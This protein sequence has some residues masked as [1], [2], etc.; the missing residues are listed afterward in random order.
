M[1]SIV[2]MTRAPLDQVEQWKRHMQAQMW[3]WVRQP[4]VKDNAG[5]YIKEGV[6]EETG[7]QMYRRGNP[8]TQRVAG[9]LRPIQLWEYTL[10]EE[11]IPEALA[12]INLHQNAKLRPEVSSYAWFLRKMMKL[13]PMPKMP[14]AMAKL[15]REDVTTRYIPMDAMGVYPIGIKKDLKQDIIFNLPGG[16]QQGWYQEHL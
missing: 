16:G 6:D 3:P 11:H 8:V 9:V 12:M 14:D 5:N 2:L 4:L 1:A 13:T 10:P 15:N 7:A